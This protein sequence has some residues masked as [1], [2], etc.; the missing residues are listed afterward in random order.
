MSTTPPPP[1]DRIHSESF[2]RELMRRQL[3]LSIGC[4]L[5]FLVALLGMPLLNYFAPGFMAIRVGGFTL[6]WLV[7]GVLF[8][9]YVWIISYFF[10][11]RSLAL[12]ASEVSE[13]NQ[14]RR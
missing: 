7:L 10:I 2:L 5:A 14:S 9:P 1:P 8:F 11:R 4:A 13:V 6:T 3:G 12:E